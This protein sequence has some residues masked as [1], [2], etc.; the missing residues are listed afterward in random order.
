MNIEQARYNMVEQQIRTWDVLDS[1]I[2]E[3]VAR[4]RREDYVPAAFRRLAFADMNIPLEHGQVMMQPKVEARLLQELEIKPSDK[5]LEVGTGSGFLTSLLAGLGKHVYSV[6]IFADF[7]RAALE[8]LA[9]HGH[10]N[11]TLEVGDAAAGWDRHAPYDVIVLTGSVPVLPE[12]FKTTLA[13]GGRL[14]AI[15]GESPAMEAL[16]ITRTANGSYAERSLFETDL[17]PLLNARAPAHF[18]F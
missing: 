12:T 4:A 16:V 8:Q 18:D 6:D 13:P 14:F 17:P 3:L 10:K 7:S 9:R 11:V 5:V 15:V 2:L 1:R